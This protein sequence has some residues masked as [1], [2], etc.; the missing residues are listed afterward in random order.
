MQTDEITDYGQET[1]QESS[2][3]TDVDSLTWVETWIESTMQILNTIEEISLTTDN[4]LDVL[5]DLQNIENEFCE[6]LNSN[7]E[8]EK[9][10]KKL[11]SVQ[12]KTTSLRDATLQTCHW[13]ELV[14][15]TIESKN[16]DEIKTLL[17]LIPQGAPH[18][19]KLKEAL[20]NLPKVRKCQKL[21][22]RLMQHIPVVQTSFEQE[23]NNSAKAEE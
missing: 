17:T 20:K 13:D 1:V 8:D 16:E 3:Q 22:K 12:E 2:S 21:A 10:Q 7:P 19:R 18:S 6:H 15:L 9:V 4:C 11:K 5:Q 14:K 23:F